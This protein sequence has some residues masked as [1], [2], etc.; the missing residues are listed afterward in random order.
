MSLSLGE[1]MDGSEGQPM[2]KN[3]NLLSSLFPS[4]FS[5]MSMLCVKDDFSGW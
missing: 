4:A 5:R 2:G 1:G 3:V